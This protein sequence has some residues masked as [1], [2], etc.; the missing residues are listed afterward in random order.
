MS[1]K[2]RKTIIC[3]NVPIF[4]LNFLMISYDFLSRFTN[5]CL[6]FDIEELTGGSFGY[7]SRLMNPGCSDLLDTKGPATFNDAALYNYRLKEA[8]YEN[9]IRDCRGLLH[10]SGLLIAGKMRQK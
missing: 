2:L 3:Y 8:G 9:R 4:F 10:K 6:G 5:K 7:I 1:E